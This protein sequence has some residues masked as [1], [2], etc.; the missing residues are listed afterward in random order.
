MVGLLMVAV[1]PDDRNCRMVA[2]LVVG[3]GVITVGGFGAWFQLGLG[4]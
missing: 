4:G 3:V 2:C 1:V